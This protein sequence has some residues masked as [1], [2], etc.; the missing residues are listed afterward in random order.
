MTGP[1][2]IRVLSDAVINQ[3]AAGEVVERPASVLKELVEDHARA[4]GSKWSA[5][6]LAG[7]ERWKGQFWQVCP[8]EMLS[9]LTQPLNDEEVA[10][11][12]AE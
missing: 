5:E 8:K 10:V 1:A 12:A 9:R 3:I 4:T 6:I 7:W 2:Q 11:E